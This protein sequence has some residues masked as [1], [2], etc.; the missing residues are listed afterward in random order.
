MKLQ[1]EELEK[2]EYEA[3]IEEVKA[4]LAEYYKHRVEVDFEWRHKIGILLLEYAEIHQVS[5]RKHVA[6]VAN[7]LKREERTIYYMA[8]FAKKFPLLSSAPLHE[9]W[10]D[11]C[12]QYLDTTKK[13]PLVELECNHRCPK[14]CSSS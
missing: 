14:H 7:S 6:T 11:I 10:R 12:H 5:L 8:Q 1:K 9:S 3:H 2:Q 4:G 13:E